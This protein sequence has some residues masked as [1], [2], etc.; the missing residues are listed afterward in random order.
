MCNI[1]VIDLLCCLNKKQNTTSEKNPEQN[2]PLRKKDDSVMQTENL[3]P[4][5]S[6]M[7]GI[8]PT[9]YDARVSD[10]SSKDQFKQR[11]SSTYTQPMD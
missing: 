5:G 10:G 7:S 9:Y 3:V 8:A 2:I 6:Y 11:N 4:F 1:C